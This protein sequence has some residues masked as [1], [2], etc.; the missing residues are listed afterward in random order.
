MKHTGSTITAANDTLTW[1]A[2][3]R[4]RTCCRRF[5]S[6]WRNTSVVRPNSCLF[7]GAGNLAQCHILFPA[8]AQSALIVGRTPRSA[9]D[10]PVGLHSMDEA[11]FDGE[12]RVQGDPCGPGYRR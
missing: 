7:C 11:D 5:S 6:S 2:T 10:A 12:E 1:C 9:A 3:P 4:F 8:T